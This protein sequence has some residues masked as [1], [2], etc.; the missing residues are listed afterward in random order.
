MG[1]SAKTHTKG[2]HPTIH[3]KRKDGGP[4]GGVTF[5]IHHG[6]DKHGSLPVQKDTLTRIL[7]I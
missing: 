4:S 1:A 2:S 7:A 3:F 6:G 5:S